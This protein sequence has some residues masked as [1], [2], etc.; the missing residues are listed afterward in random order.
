MTLI[1]S[2]R[3]SQNEE[4]ENKRNPI[5]VFSTAKSPDAV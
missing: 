5:K 3:T 1:F 4:Q 2:T